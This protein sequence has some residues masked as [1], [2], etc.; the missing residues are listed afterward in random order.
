MED[1]LHAP[2]PHEATSTLQCSNNTIYPGDRIGIVGGDQYVVVDTCHGAI[3][4]AFVRS[5]EDA[6]T[7]MLST[8]QVEER[9]ATD[10]YHWRLLA[11]ED[12]T[13]HTG[14]GVETLTFRVYTVEFPHTASPEDYSFAFGLARNP[15][16]TVQR[17]V[18]LDA[19]EMFGLF[20]DLVEN[21]LN[22]DPDSDLAHLDQWES[23]F[24]VLDGT[25]SDIVTRAELALNERFDLVFD[26]PAL[27]EH[28]VQ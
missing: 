21:A 15:G 6:S 8:E 16:D 5:K 25:V 28:D 17:P 19:V 1:N 22:P 2:T 12:T 27:N 10:H 9:L 3:E 13:V 18:D 11:A 23:T 4:G 20:D 26:E 14:E 24:P 7:A